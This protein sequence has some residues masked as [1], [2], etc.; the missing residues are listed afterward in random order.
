[1]KP[2]QPQ[3]KKPVKQT[4]PAASKSPPAR[5]KKPEKASLNERI[6][7][8]AYELYELRGCLDGYA[9][10]DWVQAEREIRGAD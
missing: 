9:H 4:R 6:A 10:E 5:R 8:R 7:K 1:M 3:K 2:K